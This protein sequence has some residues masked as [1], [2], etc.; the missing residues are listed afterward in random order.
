M[1]EIILDDIV[2][3]CYNS[4]SMKELVDE[5]NKQSNPELILDSMY[6]KIRPYA[7]NIYYRNG[8]SMLYFPLLDEPLKNKKE[9]YDRIEYIKSNCEGEHKDRILRFM[10]YETYMLSYQGPLT[11]MF[12]NFID[13]YLRD[14]IGENHDPYYALYYFMVRL[15]YWYADYYIDK[16][17]ILRVDNDRIQ[18]ELE[19]NVK[20][21]LSKFVVILQ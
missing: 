17:N 19:G 11:E 18:L 2:F 6:G 12:K 15:G 14:Y 7:W 5:Y 21:R 4:N 9:A 10:E 20:G 16:N 13:K 1:L 3:Y 8:G